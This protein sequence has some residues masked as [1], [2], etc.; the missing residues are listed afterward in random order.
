MTEEELAVM[1]PPFAERLDRPILSRSIYSTQEE[2]PD[3]ADGGEEDS[4]SS[5]SEGVAA[6]GGGGVTYRT[7][8]DRKKA[9]DRDV[10]KTTYF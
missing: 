7:R 9:H 8:N 2:R 5:S 3:G 6:V 10:F 1:Q 4:S